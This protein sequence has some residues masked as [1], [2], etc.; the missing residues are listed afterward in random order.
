ML[1]EW[2]ITL[3]HALLCVVIVLGVLFS[4]T[5]ISKGAILAILMSLFIGIRLFGTC[6]MDLVEECE[7]K[8]VLADIGAAMIIKDHTKISKYEY[9]QAAVGSLL[10]V[11][12]IKIF[13]LSIY[14]VDTLF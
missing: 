9:E 11:H 7:N 1:R 2:T 5:P 6:I 10:I 14:P 8:P 3:I 4:K 12:L 13:V